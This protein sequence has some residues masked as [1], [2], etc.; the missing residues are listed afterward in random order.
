M[1]SRELAGLS[2]PLLDFKLKSLA[3]Q[4]VQ[5]LARYVAMFTGTFYYHLFFYHCYD[6]PFHMRIRIKPV[7][8]GFFK[9]FSTL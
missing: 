2:Q 5:R 4:F 3:K 7:S 9:Y 6:H 8:H 1:R